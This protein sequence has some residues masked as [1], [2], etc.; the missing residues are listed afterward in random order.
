[1]AYEYASVAE[2]KQGNAMQLSADDA[3]ITALI[4]SAGSA[5]NNFCNRKDFGFRANGQP[6]AMEFV[7]S[8]RG[9]QWFNGLEAARII[10]VEVKDSPT[11]ADYVEWDTTDWI[12]GR[13]DPD[14]GIFGD[15]DFRP[16][17][18]VA[19]RLAG[20]YAVF[21]S[22]GSS[23]RRGF[24]S[25]PDVGGRGEPTVRITA[26]WGYSMDT[27]PEIKQAT[28]MQVGRWIMRGKTQYADSTVS[29]EFGV[30]VFRRAFETLDQDV[31]MILIMGGLVQ[32]DSP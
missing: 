8:G 22:G 14:N 5:I 10:K 1:M 21:T 15:Q 26:N 20:N 12:G 2:V 11:D 9:V 30:T 32:K 31:A 7:G 4:L 13:G 25:D 17:Q 6:S 19:T 16:Y 27:P 24:P 18:W 29:P 3:W 28:I 23:A